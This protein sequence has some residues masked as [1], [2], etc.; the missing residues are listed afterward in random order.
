[1]N[2]KSSAIALGLG[3]TTL[4]LSVPS[5]ADRQ[6]LALTGGHHGGHKKHD[7]HYRQDRHNYSFHY[8]GKEY[9]CKNFSGGEPSDHQHGYYYHCVT[10][11]HHK[12]LASYDDNHHRHYGKGGHHKGGHHNG[13]HHNGGHHKK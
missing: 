6:A 1:M 3:I 10:G 12:Y 11:K 9:Y 7:N 8:K 5:P 2:I 4:G 13:G